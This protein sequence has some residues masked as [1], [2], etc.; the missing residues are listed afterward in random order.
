MDRNRPP[1]TNRPTQTRPRNMAAQRKAP[2]SP[3]RF[4][5]SK[6]HTASKAKGFP[7]IRLNLSRHTASLRRRIRAHTA[8]PRVTARDRCRP[9]VLRIH[10]VRPINHLANRHLSTER[11]SLHRPC[12]QAAKG[13]TAPASPCS[14]STEGI[15]RLWVSSVPDRRHR[16]NTLRHHPAATE[17]RGST[18]RRPRPRLPRAAT[19]AGPRTAAG[20]RHRRKINS[21]R[22]KVA[23]TS[24]SLDGNSRTGASY[25]YDGMDGL[26]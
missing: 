19:A 20:R 16:R 13:L 7:R 10:T 25:T 23:T 26:T 15:N 8:S 11:A 14:H 6:A 2:L 12:T 22:G 1:P 4:R 9:V 21:S 24:S 17:A 3:A 18:T 5:A